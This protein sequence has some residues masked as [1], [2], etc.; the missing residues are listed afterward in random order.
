MDPITLNILIVDDDEG[1]RKLL[2]RT[3][4]Q[5]GLA[6]EC[7]ET[8][9]IEDAVNACNNI[10]FDCAIIDY[11]LP[12]HDGLAGIF[13][14]NAQC[15]GM[16]IIMST[17]QGN[18]D[19][20]AEAIKNGASDYIVKKNLSPESLK[21]SIS[22]AI[23]KRRL[24][25]KL[26]EKEFE[27][28]HIAHHDYLTNIPNRHFFNLI[29]LKELAHAKRLK[30]MCAV[31][32]LDLDRFKNINDS[33][34]HEAGD[35]LLKQVS[36]RFQSVMREE[37]VLARLGGDEF[38]IL[39]GNMK[40][41]SDAEICAKKII[42]ILKKSFLLVGEKINIT[43]SI[44]IAVYPSGGKT[45]SDLM[46]NADK[47]MYQAKNDGKN[48]FQFYSSKIKQQTSQRL[49]IEIALR[50]ALKKQEFYL[51]YQPIYR[52]SDTFL[53]GV[54]VLLRWR[55][56]VYGKVPIDEII[57][58]AEES[59][60]IV[61]MGDWII[62][63]AFR[64]YK[65]WNLNAD[66]SIKLA[67]NLS[68]RQLDADDWLCKLKKLIQSH[69]IDPNLL[70]FELTETDVIREMRGIKEALSLI[71]A[72]GAQ[73]YID[74]FGMGYSSLKMIRNLPISGLKIDKSCIEG[75]ENIESDRSL[76]K[77]L[78]M[79]AENM[80]FVAVAEG[81][82]TQTQFELLKAYAHGNGQGYYLS[83]PLPSDEI[84]KLLSNRIRG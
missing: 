8:M 60:L 52:L 27:I 17:G 36:K 21:K 22:N 6:C 25:K 48:N 53:L 72:W 83:R 28:N 46:R 78:F 79:L 12:G 49:H 61:Q 50:E 51:C 10:T 65:S 20:A 15:P 35:S 19:V 23:E 32:F 57:S 68:P 76:V 16:A 38:G 77:S 44:G 54:E 84:V 80:G 63:E 59:G 56:E 75:L 24:E 5:S 1:D 13:I 30:Q 64:E 34:G 18:E 42:N 31:F 66:T 7:T 55:H 74:D 70:I 11:Q 14:L 4:K 2:Q 47:A 37:D 73:I 71:T 62:N 39:I 67:L 58:V 41:L 3:L 26:K 9:G 43:S 29:V 81:I 82:E 69:Q 40:D 33:L 45:I